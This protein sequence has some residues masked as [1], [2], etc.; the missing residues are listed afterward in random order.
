MGLDNF[1]KIVYGWKFEGQ[2]MENL[3]NDLEEY[4]D[5]YYDKLQEFIVDDTMCGNYLYVGPVLE[6]YDAVWDPKEVI[7]NEELK[8]N[9]INNWET[10]NKENPKIAE[11]FNKYIKGEP[12]LYVFQQIW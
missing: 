4:D 5:E 6:S 3:Q 11:I 10:F 1:T 9:G 12:Q 7:I 2:E 8:N